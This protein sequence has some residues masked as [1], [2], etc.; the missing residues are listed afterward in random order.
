MRK[1]SA[2]VIYLVQSVSCRVVQARFVFLDGL[3]L[4]IQNVIMQ[5]YKVRRLCSQRRMEKR[6]LW[7][8]NF[9]S[10]W[11]HLTNLF[12]FGADLMMFVYFFLILVEPIGLI[13][14][15]EKYHLNF[16]FFKFY[17]EEAQVAGTMD[18]SVTRCIARQFTH[19]SCSSFLS[20][21]TIKLA[22]PTC[23]MLCSTCQ[24][25]IPAFELWPEGPFALATSWILPKQTP[26]FF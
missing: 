10:T 8:H 13:T 20:G 17:M 15:T 11:T 23:T 4:C 3:K 25:L 22:A 9:A 16:F 7:C 18:R 12:G 26:V 14:S 5:C 2:A 24:Q 6:T 21:C 1:W 19:I